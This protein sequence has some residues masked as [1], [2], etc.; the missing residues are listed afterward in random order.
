MLKITLRHLEF[1]NAL[2][3]TGHFGHAADR[4]GVT[5]P[6][7]SLKI[8]ELEDHFGAPLI[9]RTQR[10]F[11]PTSLG[12]DVAQQSHAI[13]ANLAALERQAHRARGQEGPFKLGIIPTIAPYLLPQALE[14]L[15]TNIPNLDVHIREGQTHQLLQ[16]LDSGLLDAAVIATATDPSQY[17]EFE[18]FQD[19]FI[20]AITKT[21]ADALGLRSGHVSSADLSQLRMLLLENGH[22]LRDQTL[23]FCKLPPHDT[24]VKLGASSLFTLS[25][26]VARGHGATLLPELSLEASASDKNTVFLRLAAPEPARTIRLICRRTMHDTMA[27]DDLMKTLRVAGERTIAQNARQLIQ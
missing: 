22:C 10:P 3:D 19:H 5:Q 23:Q 11:K 4:L 21:Q 18:L 1:L 25:R 6:A 26:L 2:I 12:R 20:L 9:D 16:E 7:L 13:I 24:L 15:E 17:A 8:K 27:L 14:L